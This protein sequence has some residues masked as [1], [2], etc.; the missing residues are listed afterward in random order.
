MTDDRPDPAR[1]LAAS[2]N[3]ALDALRAALTLQQ[4][5][6]ATHERTAELLAKLGDT[7]RAD[8]H[9][10]DAARARAWERRARLLLSRANRTDGLL[11]LRT[12]GEP[13]RR[14]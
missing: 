9:R 10:A 12:L 4:D 13:R 7:D 8:R 6:T 1:R 14:D 5:A 2:R 3:T 11:Q